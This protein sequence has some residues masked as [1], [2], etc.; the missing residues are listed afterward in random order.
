MANPR[1]LVVVDGSTVHRR[2]LA[3]ND[4]D[5]AKLLRGM[6]GISSDGKAQ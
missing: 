4:G 3:S 1:R 5:M 2:W 6:L